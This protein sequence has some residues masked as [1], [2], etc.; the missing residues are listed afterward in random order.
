MLSGKN[1]EERLIIQNSCTAYDVFTRIDGQAMSYDTDY[2][3]QEEIDFL[4]FIA[5]ATRSNQLFLINAVQLNMVKLR[6]LYDWFESKL[7][8]ISPNSEFIS[9][10]RLADPGDVLSEHAIKLMRILGT[11]IDHFETVK[12]ADIDSSLPKK[13]L[14]GIK[15][16][17]SRPDDVNGSNDIIV[18]MENDELVFEKLLAIHK[19]LHGENIRFQLSEESDGTKRLL[20]L[21]PALAKLKKGQGT[22]FVIDELDRSLHTQLPEWLLKYFL[23][24]CHADSRNQLIFTTH[25]VNILTQDLFR[26]TNCGESTKTLM[27]LPFFIHS[28]TSKKIRS[29][30][31]IRKVYLNGL[32]GAVPTIL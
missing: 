11:G 22:V 17:M 16:K 4:N 3:N 21:I 20:D 1:L 9:I 12:L 6:P 18:R 10:Q 23:D 19:N 27:A 26:V 30:R 24:V 28:G 5:K 7:T 15:Q 13:L 31:N 14:S 8:V 25:D 32:M 2:F 29:D